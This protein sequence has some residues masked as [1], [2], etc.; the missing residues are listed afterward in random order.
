MRQL[1]L[2]GSITSGGYIIS[3]CGS[4][5]SLTQLLHHN[6]AIYTWLNKHLRMGQNSYGGPVTM[7][8]TTLLSY[9]IGNVVSLC[10]IGDDV[11]YFLFSISIFNDIGACH[12]LVDIGEMMFSI[13]YFLYSLTWEKCHSLRDIGVTMSYSSRSIHLITVCTT[14]CYLLFLCIT[15]INWHPTRCLWILDHKVS[16]VKSLYDTGLWAP[17][18][19]TCPPMPVLLVGCFQ[20]PPLC[21]DLA[22]LQVGGDFLLLRGAGLCMLP[23]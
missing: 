4:A 20:T 18:W 22:S 8:I 5:P 23:Y 11:V 21:V 6:D 3:S 12:S 1:W 16:L 10:D 13:F 14:C 17:A 15:I 19:Y 7:N 9:N 2:C